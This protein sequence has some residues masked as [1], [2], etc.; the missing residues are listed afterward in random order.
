MSSPPFSLLLFSTDA[1]FVSEAT[2]AGVDGVVVDWEREGKTQRQAHADTQIGADTV[3]DLRRVRAATR[4]RVHC[5]INRYGPGTAREVAQ[6]LDEGVDELLLPMVRSPDEVQRV[7][8]LTAGRCGVGVLVETVDA[9]R[10]AAA[11]AQLPLARA[12]VGLNDLAIERG[13]RTIFAPVEDGTL[14]L[15][16]RSFKVPFGFGGLTLPE[17][18]APIPCRLL[19]A[20]MA[21]L[22]CHYSFLRRSFL[23][24]V[25]GRDVSVEVPRLL[26]AI[27]QLSCRSEEAVE[28]DRLALRRAIARAEAEA[29]TAAMPER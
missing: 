13:S 11:L 28:V 9:V 8:D 10:E 17:A 22:S 6:A 7:L 16:R 4:A 18:G 19:M 20:E 3:E 2:A 12:Y 21:R 27:A 1:A 5:R 25:R 23:R 14:Q 29:A 26:A 15:V 24:D